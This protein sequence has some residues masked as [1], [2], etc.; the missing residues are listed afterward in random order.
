MTQVFYEGR[1]VVVLH[2]GRKHTRVR[3]V[4]DDV[5]GLPT[6]LAATGSLYT[7]HP[8]SFEKPKPFEK[9]PPELEIMHGVTSVLRKVVLADMRR[10]P[11]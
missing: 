8:P 10:R 6:F 11:H 4:G 3:Y 2:R 9:D 5:E 1:E 7:T